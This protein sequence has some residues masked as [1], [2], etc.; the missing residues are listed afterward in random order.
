MIVE[1]IKWDNLLQVC[2]KL[3]SSIESLLSLII[4]FQLIPIHTSWFPGRLISR[5]LS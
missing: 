1:N 5:I 2:S 3:W 4:P